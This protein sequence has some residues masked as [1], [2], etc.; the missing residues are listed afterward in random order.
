MNLFYVDRTYAFYLTRSYRLSIQAQKTLDIPPRI[1]PDPFNQPTR[2]HHI[3][4]PRA[5]RQ[6]RT[7]EISEERRS[8]R[9][10]VVVGRG[11]G[12]VARFPDQ[13]CFLGSGII[14]V[15][16]AAAAAAVW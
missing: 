1:D 12:V 3:R 15:I 5:E 9:A 8:A 7:A 13:E 4:S 16:R 10:A 2:S 11:R 14:V 6:R